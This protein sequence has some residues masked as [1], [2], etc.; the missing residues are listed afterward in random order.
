[1]LGLVD[2]RT[3]DAKIEAQI[4]QGGPLH[5]GEGKSVP[6]WCGVVEALDLAHIFDLS[7]GSGALAMACAR[8]GVGYDGIAANEKHAAWVDNVLDHG[9]LAAL[10]DP[11]SA[12]HDKE[13]KGKIESYFATAVEQARRYCGDYAGDG[14]EQEASDDES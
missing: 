9:V 10:T 7:V 4:S 8:S 5:W 13:V 1:M 6:F 2:V 12:A 3:Y 11:K 14:E